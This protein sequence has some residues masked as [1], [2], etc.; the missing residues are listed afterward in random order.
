MLGSVL[1]RIALVIVLKDEGLETNKNLYQIQLDD[2]FKQI[3][4][5]TREGNQLF[6]LSTTIIIH[7]I[8]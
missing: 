8:W 2:F 4:A 1:F 7:K 3:L 6:F 5:T